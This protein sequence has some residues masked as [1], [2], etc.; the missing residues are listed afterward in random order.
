[1]A[2][3]AVAV[4]RRFAFGGVP[5]V[6]A[7]DAFAAIVALQLGSGARLT[8][9]ARIA[10]AVVARAIGARPGAIRIPRER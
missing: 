1:M 5:T 10:D 6:G 4:R 3:E 7:G 2:P 9:A 8:E